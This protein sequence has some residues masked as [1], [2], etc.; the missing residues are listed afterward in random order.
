MIPYMHPSFRSTFDTLQKSLPHATLLSGEKGVGLATLARAIAGQNTL[1]ISP[2]DTDGKPS[3]K[4]SITAAI[5]RQLY[6]DTRSIHERM[7]IIIDDADTMTPAAQSACLKLFEEPTANTH[8][9]LTSHRPELLLPTIRSR[10]QIHHV[11][12]LTDTQTDELIASFQ[13]LSDGQ[14]SQLRFIAMGRPSKIVS[15]ATDETRLDAASKLVRDARSFLTASRRFERLTVALEYAHRTKAL[16]IVDMCISLTR[17]SIKSHPDQKNLALLN[18]LLDTHAAIY[19]N[20][21][22]RLQLLR[23]TLI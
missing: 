23:L 5:I 14:K 22:P 15:Y 12:L 18:S 4:G 7:V 20:Q 3:E 2:M 11:P 16:D 6:T 1:F 13:N 17:Y 21:N 9:I 10:L 19:A 8:F